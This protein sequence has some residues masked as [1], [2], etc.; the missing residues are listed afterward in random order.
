MQQKSKIFCPQLFEILFLL[1]KRFDNQLHI[2]VRDQKRETRLLRVYCKSLE[3]DF[4][5]MRYFACPQ[6]QMIYL[7]TTASHSPQ[8]S[9]MCLILSTNTNEIRGDITEI[10]IIL[11]ASE[12]DFHS[13]IYDNFNSFLNKRR[14]FK[15]FNVL[16]FLNFKI[17]KTI[18]MSFIE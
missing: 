8:I 10:L 15:I 4:E 17:K 11:L 14:K 6:C 5:R 13:R 7:K 3:L 2:A 9:L 1:F 16:C 18:L 12:T